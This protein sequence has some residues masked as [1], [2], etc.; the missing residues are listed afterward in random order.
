MGKSHLSNFGSLFRFLTLRTARLRQ[1]PGHPLALAATW[2]GGALLVG[3]IEYLAPFP[4]LDLL[5]PFAWLGVAVLGGLLVSRLLDRNVD[6]LRMAFAFSVVTL[7]AILLGD[8]ARYAAQ[9]AI[10]LPVALG[11]VVTAWAV[12][13]IVRLVFG[14]ADAVGAG[15]RVAAVLVSA[16]A[17]FTGIHGSTMYERLLA[18][19]YQSLTSEDD[20]RTINQEVLWTAQPRLVADA[21]A[22][23]SGSISPGADVHVISIAAGGLQ[24]IFG[25]EAQALGDLLQ[26]RFDSGG[27]AIILSNAWDDLQQTPLANRTNISVVLNAIGEGFDPQS[28][29]AVIYLTAH[30]GRDATLQ[31]GLPDYSQ[32]QSISAD[33][34]ADALA[35]A[36]ITRRVIIVSACYAGSWIEPL[37]T[38][39]T[40]ILAAAR[41]DRT[42]FG[43]DDSR[44]YTFYGEA[45]LASGLGEGASLEAAQAKLEQSI[46]DAESERNLEPS[47]PQFFVGKNMQDLWAASER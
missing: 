34:L 28:D 14:A 27:E 30:G 41:A 4:V 39:D 24:D 35:E 1:L 40:I 8:A 5:S 3:L 6:A 38:R 11:I 26:R 47:L 32:L 37:A 42:S 20:F 36:G 7:F 13:A 10:W 16:V 2:L 17:I 15:R 21:A 19:H 18:A 9:Y 45:M 46:G 22:P 25:R 23:L 12:S 43:C 31:T 29:L 33:F 44:E